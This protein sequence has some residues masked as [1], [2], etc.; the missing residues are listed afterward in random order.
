MEKPP[1]TSVPKNLTQVYQEI[2]IICYTVREMWRGTDVI[3]I[4]HFG[5][6]FPFYSPNNPRKSK[7]Q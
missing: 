7:P 5:L 2:M 3:F 6:F 4:L 1:E